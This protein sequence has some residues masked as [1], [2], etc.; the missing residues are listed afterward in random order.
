MEGS[1]VF[2]DYI[3]GTCREP[4]AD[5]GFGQGGPQLQRPKVADVAKQAICGWGPGPA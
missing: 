3:V 4:G 1:G 2:L 5:P